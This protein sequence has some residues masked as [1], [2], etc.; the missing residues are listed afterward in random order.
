MDAEADEKR[1]VGSAARTVS[2]ALEDVTLHLKVAILGAQLDVGREHHLYVLL[3]L[4]QH[5]RSASAY[6]RRHGEG[7]ASA[8]W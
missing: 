3:L 6:R 2:A 1:R 5:P 8:V 7:E 4:G